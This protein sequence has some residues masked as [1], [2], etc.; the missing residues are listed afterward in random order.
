[1]S[2]I[3][4]QRQWN[5]WSKANKLTAIGTLLGVV[6]LIITLFQFFGQPSTPSQ[7]IDSKI[8]VRESEGI[9]INIGNH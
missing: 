8:S 5:S 4:S 1:M 2:I 6:S 7:K 9:E 3:P